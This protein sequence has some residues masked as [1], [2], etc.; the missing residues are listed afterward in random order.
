MSVYVDVFG[1]FH[2]KW[3]QMNGDKASFG[4]MATN[5]TAD[6]F[7]AL[8]SHVRIHSGTIDDMEALGQQIIDAAR[9]LRRQGKEAA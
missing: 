8:V 9:E 7:G 2:L 5:P 6:P 1:P 3:P 4:L